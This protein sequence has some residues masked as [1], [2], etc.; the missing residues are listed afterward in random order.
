MKV[1]YTKAQ[2]I[3]N[4][5][6]LQLQKILDGIQDNKTVE[7]HEAYSNLDNIIDKLTIS[8]NEFEYL[9]S[10][11]KEGFLLLDNDTDKYFINYS[12]GLESSLL[13]CGSTLEIFNDGEWIIGRVEA[14]DGKYY[15]YGLDKP[16]LF[17]GLKVRKRIF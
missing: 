5:A 13:S 1:E 14:R 12:D 8:E 15:F 9:N 4:K 7:D 17:V 6:R 3:I 16:F 11:T 10:P 2:D